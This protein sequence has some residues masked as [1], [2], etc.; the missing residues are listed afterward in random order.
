VTERCPGQRNYESPAPQK[1]KK[2]KGKGREGE[3]RRGEGRK[4]KVGTE[5]KGRKERREGKARRKGRGGIRENTGNKTMV[6]GTACSSCQVL[7]EELAHA[8]KKDYSGKSSFNSKAAN[9]QK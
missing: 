4:K 7:Y 3:E 8:R 5:R 6:R 1:Q 2:K 9:Y